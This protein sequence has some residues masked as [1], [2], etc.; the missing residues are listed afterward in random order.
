MPSGET[1]VVE[2]GYLESNTYTITA[3]AKDESGQ[4]SGEATHSIKVTLSK[5]KNKPKITLFF[6]KL[7]N[8]FPNLW[9]YLQIFQLFLIKN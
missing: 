6:E 9:K 3:K 5:T 1:L 8:L 7:Q 4:F 2:K